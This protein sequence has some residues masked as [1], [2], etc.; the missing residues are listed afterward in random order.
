VTWEVGD[1]A[2]CVDA[3]PRPCSCGALH[4]GHNVTEGASY[5]VVALGDPHSFGESSLVCD[6]LC[7][8]MDHGKSGLAERFRKIRPDEH[9]K[10]EPEFV[11]LLKRRKV[12]A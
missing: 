10:C 3:A 4:T 2:M 8:L 6:K 12:S 7:L 11:T 9:E 1:L 5:R